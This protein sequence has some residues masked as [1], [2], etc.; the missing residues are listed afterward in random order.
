M[1]FPDINYLIV[2]K[3]SSTTVNARMY[4]T[5]TKAISQAPTTI[6]ALIWQDSRYKGIDYTTMNTNCYNEIR[7]TL[8]SYDGVSTVRRSQA[9]T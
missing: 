8:T 9:Q 6:P 5:T 7:G 1:A 2:H 4:V 3:K